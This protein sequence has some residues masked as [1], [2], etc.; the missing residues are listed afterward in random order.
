LKLVAVVAFICLLLDDFGSNLR[1]E[2]VRGVVAVDGVDGR[3]WSSLSNSNNSIPLQIGGC[4]AGLTA[5]LGGI[6]SGRGVEGLNNLK[7]LLVLSG[8]ASFE[9]LEVWRLDCCC[10]DSLLVCFAIKE[11]LSTTVLFLEDAR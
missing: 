5:A 8:S 10:V 6:D 3:A 7:D 9:L 11:S 4:A 1:A 2:N